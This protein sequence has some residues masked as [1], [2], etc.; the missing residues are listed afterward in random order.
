MPAEEAALTVAREREPHGLGV[1]GRV[2]ECPVVGVRGRY[3]I[4]YLL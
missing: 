2:E 3:Q 1:C 4:V